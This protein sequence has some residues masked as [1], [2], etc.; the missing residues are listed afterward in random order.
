MSRDD[1]PSLLPQDFFAETESSISFQPLNLY[2]S[3]YDCA[4]AFAGCFHSSSSFKKPLIAS[5]N[6]H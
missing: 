2:I 4:P 5:Y 3:F 1:P 6:F